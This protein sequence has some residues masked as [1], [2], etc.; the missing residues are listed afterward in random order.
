MYMVL[1]YP[2]QLYEKLYLYL[3]KKSFELNDLKN[4]KHLDVRKIH[5]FSYLY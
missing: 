4:K 5:N 1:L 2:K 3:I